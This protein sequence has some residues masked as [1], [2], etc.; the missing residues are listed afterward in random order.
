MRDEKGEVY[1]VR[2]EADNAMWLKSSSK[3]IAKCRSKM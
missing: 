3:S 1:S 2:Y